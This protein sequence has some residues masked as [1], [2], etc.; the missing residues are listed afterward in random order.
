MIKDRLKRLFTDTDVDGVLILNTSHVDPSFKYFS[1]LTS[2]IFEGSALIVKQKSVKLIT[3]EL[4][5][6]TA[7]TQMKKGVILAKTKEQF[8]KKINRELYGTIGVDYNFLPVKKFRGIRKKINFKIKDVSSILNEIRMIKD[9]DEIKNISEAGKIVSKVAD[10]IPDFLFIN[11]SELEIKAE[12][13]YLCTKFGSSK[14]PFSIIAFGKNSAYPHHTS[15]NTRINK[16]DFILCDFGATVN[17][18]N[19]D[20]SR[21]FI[22]KKI[23]AKQKKIYQTVIE[24]QQLAL[25]AIQPGADSSEIHQIAENHINKAGF[26]GRFIHSLGHM[27]GLEVHEGKVV[28]K[29]DSFEIDEGMVFTVEPGIYIPNL[30]GVRIEDDIVV[31]KNGCKLLTNAKKGLNVIS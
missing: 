24:A 13:D 16:G 9:R 10:K 14:I 21:T 18:Y 23:T 17:H 19:S 29:R 20:L 11:K 3:G 8:W 30:G 5:Y 12:I 27:I 15:G 31:T 26:K 7:K 25:D 28:S 2:G 4:E 1:G 22:Y 6:Q